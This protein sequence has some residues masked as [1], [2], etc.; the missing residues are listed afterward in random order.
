MWE[1]RI[2]NDS[3][4]KAGYTGRGWKQTTEKNKLGNLGWKLLSNWCH[5]RRYFIR[6]SPPFDIEWDVL[7]SFSREMRPPTI[8]S[9]THPLLSTFHYYADS[10]TKEAFDWWMGHLMMF[11]ITGPVR[12]PHSAC[13]PL[14]DAQLSLDMSLRH[15]P[16]K[17]RM[18]KTKWLHS[19]VLIK[20]ATSH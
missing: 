6:F 7:L 9:S 17:F 11:L 16:F 12:F 3:G 18:F 19:C 1:D 8:Y 15:H 14:S 13:L 4:L 2:R 10:F 5:L 20:E